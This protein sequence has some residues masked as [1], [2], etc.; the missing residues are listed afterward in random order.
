[1]VAKQANKTEGCRGSLLVLL[2]LLLPLLRNSAPKA[3]IALYFL[4]KAMTHKD[5]REDRTHLMGKKEENCPI[6]INLQFIFSVAIGQMNYAK[7]EENNT[8]SSFLSFLKHD[9]VPA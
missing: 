6:L 5:F 8:P 4:F 7:R 9:P 1:M 3:E 2:G